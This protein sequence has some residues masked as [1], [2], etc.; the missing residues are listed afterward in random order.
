[1]SSFLS[2]VKA[3]LLDRRIMPLLALV[4]AGLLAAG[5]YAVLG[6][7][8]TTS[9]PSTAS[10]GPAAPAG[11]TGIAV[12]QASNTNGAVAETTSGIT[13]QHKGSARNPFAPLPGTVHAAA[14][15]TT[16]PSTASASTPSSGTTSSP[17]SG[18]SPVTPSKPSAPFKPRTVYDVAVLFGVIPTPGSTT[19]TP[20]LTPYESLKLLTPLPSSKQPLVVFRGV[21]AGGK[22]A[23]FT[24]VGEA[25]LHGNGT[26]LPSATQCQAVDLQVNQSEQLEYLAPTGETVTYELRIVSITPGTASTASVKSL[27][28][29]ESKAVRELLR[30]DGLLTLPGLRYSARAGVLVFAGHPPF[31]AAARRAHRA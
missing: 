10:T 30:G 3:D 21:T 24:L 2:S 8:S 14:A 28:R 9:A 12:T 18:S 23:T 5:A 19:E 25:I 15:T 27:Q 29:G 7:G 11:A 31:A 6:G 13:S 20:P 16:T 26:C 22:N 17:S 1:M 4:A